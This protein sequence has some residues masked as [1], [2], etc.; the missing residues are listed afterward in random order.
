M[1]LPV[2]TLIPPIPSIELNLPNRLINK[3]DVPTIPRIGVY[4]KKSIYTP[5]IQLSMEYMSH[6][7][8]IIEAISYDTFNDKWDIIDQLYN[9]IALLNQLTNR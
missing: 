8:A 9:K 7:N 2:L 5:K 4:F 1:K 6:V 3:M